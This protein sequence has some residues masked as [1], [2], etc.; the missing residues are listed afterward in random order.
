MANAEKVL[1]TAGNPLVYEPVPSE[2]AFTEIDRENSRLWSNLAVTRGQVRDALDRA[3]R[4]EFRSFWL[5]LV[6]GL[7]TAGGLFAVAV[8]LLR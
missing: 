1:Y 4:A 2:S 6:V 5:G 3:E 8:Y 7:Y